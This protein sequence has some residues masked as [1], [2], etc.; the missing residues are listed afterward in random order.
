M[1]TK[2]ELNY[3]LK[4]LKWKGDIGRCLCPVHADKVP[5]LNIKI[6]HD[7]VLMH[8]KGC[9]ANGKEIMEAIGEPVYKLFSS[10]KDGYR[11][12]EAYHYTNIITGHYA[13][14]RFRC[15]D[16]GV[17][18]LPV[19]IKGSSEWGL[20]GKR[21]EDF[22]AMY[23]GE[24]ITLNQIE[25][26][27]HLC[28]CEGEKDVNTL[29]KCGYM[30]VTSGSAT[31]WQKCF[32]SLFRDKRVIIFRDNDTP[33]LIYALNAYK[34]IRRVAKDVIVINPCDE[35]K[36]GDISDYLKSHTTEDLKQMIV[37]A[38]HSHITPLNIY[39]LTDMPPD[40]FYLYQ[41]A[42]ELQ[43]MNNGNPFEMPHTF[44]QA[45]G[46][47]KE[48]RERELKTKKFLVDNAYLEI[49]RKGGKI[50]GQFTSDLY[51]VPSTKS[52]HGKN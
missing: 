14:T 27:K 40:A 45:I 22:T 3:R 37:K 36:G 13:F 7:R 34:D 35:I 15:V 33:G 28:L 29:N 50:N 49:V 2:S 30:A 21:E 6:E 10:P 25:R 31:S 12:E 24:N 18:R 4:G 9:G 19:K 43:T 23:L 16:N 48:N 11:I 42:V 51:I 1:I 47:S 46:F 44:L 52:V 8:C 38:R 20:Q 5:S 17:K 39:D 41:W 26:K 32:A